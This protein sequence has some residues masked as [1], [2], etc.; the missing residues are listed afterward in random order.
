MPRQ[1]VL[2]IIPSPPNQH[3]A[4]K[5]DRLLSLSLSDHLNLT[6]VCLFA[7]TSVR[8]MR[9]SALASRREM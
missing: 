7:L 1:A 2:A 8:S 4:V 9:M 3:M 6:A 5:P